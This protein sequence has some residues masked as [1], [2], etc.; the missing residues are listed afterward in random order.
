MFKSASNKILKQ[1][2]PLLINHIMKHQLSKSFHPIYDKKG[3]V[4]TKKNIR[5]FRISKIRE[6]FRL[7]WVGLYAAHTASGPKLGL[8]CVEDIVNLRL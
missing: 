3:F 1:I 7:G 4:T 5:K 2:T 6:D 8:G